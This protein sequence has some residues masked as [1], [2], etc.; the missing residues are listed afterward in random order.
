MTHTLHRHGRFLDRDFVVL[1]MSA[2]GINES[3]SAEKLR[4]FLRLA[5]KHHPVNFGDIKSGNRSELSIEDLLAR[6]EDTSVV[7]AAFDALAPVEAFVAELGR[8]DL[9][10]SIV[11]TGDTDDV[12]QMCVRRFNR[13]PHTVEHSLGIWGRIDRLP[14]ARLLE[15]TT[16]CGHA[17]VSARLVEKLMNEVKSGRKTPEEAAAELARPCVC[18][19][20]NPSRAAALLA[21]SV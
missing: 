19:V 2:K 18:G 9:G 11:V 21:K 7:H 5:D 13:E 17:V 14:P 4:A 8:A 6:V 3:G 10:L 20:F 1:A 16:M 12:R 15:V